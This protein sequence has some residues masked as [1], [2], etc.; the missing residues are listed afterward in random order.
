[1][2]TAQLIIMNDDMAAAAVSGFI[3]LV[4]STNDPNDEQIH[5]QSAY[6]KHHC[7]CPIAI[8]VYNT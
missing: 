6:A 1:M 4:T 2:Y 7:L 3:P 8:F 5:M